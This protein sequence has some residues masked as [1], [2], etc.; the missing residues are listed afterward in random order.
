MKNLK[1]NFKIFSYIKSMKKETISQFEN[2]SKIYLSVI[3]LDRDDDISNN[4]YNQVIGIINDS[5]FNI[6][7]DT[8]NFLYKDEKNDKNNNI[9]LEEL[10]HLKNKIQIK[11]ENEKNIKENVKY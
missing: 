2:Y 6:L 4:I 9:T 10:I 1:D 5:T 11:N 8:E 7:Q 3:E